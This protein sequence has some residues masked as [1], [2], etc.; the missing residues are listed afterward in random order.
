[1]T[2]LL[3]HPLAQF[4]AIGIVVYAIV[5]W[6]S[7]GMTP[8][9]PARSGPSTQTIVVERDELLAY[10]Q[11]RSGEADAVALATR[12]DALDAGSREAWV[13]RY[14]REEVLVREARR[15]GLDQGDDL[16]RRRLVQQMEFIAAD[17][18]A[19][20]VGIPDE[21]VEAYYRAQREDYR[22]PVLLTFAHVFVR[23][24]EE[25]AVRLLGRLNTE[26]I[27]FGR[28]GAFGDRFLYNRRYVERTDG[29][30]RSH[31]GDAMI[32]Q[33]LSLA[34]SSTRWQGPIGSDHGWHLVLLSDRVE[35]SIRPLAQAAPEIRRDLARQREEAALDAGVRAIVSGYEIRLDSALT[36]DR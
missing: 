16:I 14:V 26:R 30:V 12:F 9:K 5:S 23:E 4:L 8:Q 20:I 32:E 17:A 11:L 27:E 2:R 33:L 34:P 10:V 22:E 3:I 7:E 24:D 25:A 21:D 18:A 6:Q 19:E 28:A 31:F 13:D 1:M 15:L 35:S 36:A 29:E